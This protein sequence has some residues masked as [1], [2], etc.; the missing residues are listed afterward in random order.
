MIPTASINILNIAHRGARAYAPENTLVAFAKA[1]TLG[2]D[3]FEMDVR[4]AK[5]GTVIVYH[6]ESLARCTNVKA[7]FPDCNSD[8]VADFTYAELSRLDAGR[9]Y[10]A[11]LDLPRE[12]RLPFLQ[13]LD[14]SELA[15]FVSVPERER[16]ASGEIKIPTLVETL[17]LAKELELMVNIEL[18]NQPNSQ[19]GLVEA[20][21]E[22]ILAIQLEDQVLISSFDHALLQQ[23]RQQTSRIAIAVLTEGPIKAPVAYL[24]TLKA[25]AYNIGCHKDYRRHGFGGLSGKRYLT[26]ID[27]VRNAGF[28]VN[29]W[30]CNDP[31]EMVDL[32]AAGVT[33]LISDY[34][35]RVAEAIKSFAQGTC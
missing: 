18:K 5:D 26:H 6:D 4:L 19:S 24:R 25:N 15:D 8:H 21:L 29:V 20:V 1:K 13:N 14:D 31:Q 16:Y 12:E 2:C 3:M 32:L 11:Q 33:G 30:T 7:K 17:S 23:V 10:I 27:E 28:D 9:W 22:D 35:N 34:P